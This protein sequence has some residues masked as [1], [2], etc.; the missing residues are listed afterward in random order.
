MCVGGL[1]IA[2][3]I[4]LLVYIF[5]RNSTDHSEVYYGS[6]ILLQALINW[7]HFMASYRLLYKPASNIRKYPFATIYVPILLVVA[8]GTA[9]V[10]GGAS[11]PSNSGLYIQQD[12]AYFMWLIAAFYL[13]WHYTGQ[14]WGMI[15]SFS[16]LAG[17][18]LTNW[19]RLTL[20]TGLRVLLLWHVIW[21]AQD[22]PQQWLGPVYPYIPE[23][24]NLVSAVAIAA[25]VIGAMTFAGIKGRTGLKPTPQMLAPWIAV[26]LWYLVLFFEPAAYIFVQFSHALQYLIFPLRVEINRNESLATNGPGLKQLLW[27]GRY[28]S[29]LVL[30][31]LLVFYAPEILIEKSPQV[32]SFALLLASGVSIHHYFVDSRIWKLS[33]K[34]VR[35]SLFSHI[36]RN[37]S[38]QAVPGK[39]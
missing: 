19:E 35:T 6:F 1:S 31:G 15:A 18:T 26:Y 24:L 29:L 10:I 27:S 23:L 13:A 22:L 34:E 37:T 3:M 2:L 25:F 5:L 17:I 7:P 39:F 8:I 38:R 21:G 28:Y 32:Y 11:A 36:N 4:G 12:I 20:R 16:Y 33:N 14:A 30:L 9:V